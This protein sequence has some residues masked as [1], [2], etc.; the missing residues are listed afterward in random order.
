MEFHFCDF[1]CVIFCPDLCVCPSGG[2]LGDTPP[3]RD[4]LFMGPCK[5]PKGTDTKV[6]SAKGVSDNGLD[7]CVCRSLD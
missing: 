2:P 4:K 7:D 6:T 1:W 3:S 5:A